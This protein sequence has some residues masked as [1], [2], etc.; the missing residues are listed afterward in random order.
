[1]VSPFC[2]RARPRRTQHSLPV[3][4]GDQLECTLSA[5][6]ELPDKTPK[7]G[8]SAKEKEMCSGA[9]FFK[10]VN[11]IRDLETCGIFQ[12]NGV[13]TDMVTQSN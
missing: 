12:L 11:V 13:Q 1:M 5:S 9:M 10:N 2:R 7:G 6:K 3:C 8:N 4:A